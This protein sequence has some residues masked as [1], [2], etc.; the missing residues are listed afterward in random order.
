VG[1]KDAVRRLA[2]Q[3]AAD[4][5]KGMSVE[6]LTPE[7]TWRSVLARHI[8]LSAPIDGNSSLDRRALELAAAR[9]LNDTFGMWGHRCLWGTHHEHNGHV[10]IH[11]L[12]K[13]R[14][15]LG[16]ALRFT[17][18]ALLLDRLREALADAAREFGLDVE[19]TRHA[20][21]PELVE[22][23]LSGR[24]LLPDS[25]REVAKSKERQNAQS[26]AARLVT[27]V[28]NRVPKWFYR[29]GDSY[30][31]RQENAGMDPRQSFWG[32]LRARPSCVP[33]GYEDLAR[34]MEPTFGAATAKAL[35]RFDEMRREEVFDR[36]MNDKSPVPRYSE[37]LL[38]HHPALFAAVS[39]AA[40]PPERVR[41]KRALRALPPPG[42]PIREPAISLHESNAS[43]LRRFAQPSDHGESG[44]R[45]RDV[46]KVVRHLE[47]LAH[48]DERL[49]RH[50]EAMDRAVALRDRANEIATTTLPD[51]G[52]ELQEYMSRQIRYAKLR[53][54][55]K[56]RS[57]K[58]NE[59]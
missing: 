23:L 15:D 43:L 38:L 5:E 35:E 10:H 46:R 48:A 52:L 18:D 53:S 16:E 21:R 6:D 3:A 57:R 22:D 45:L 56:R 41:M 49:N 19:A 30:R 17:K 14:N 2:A 44:R 59:H 1:D 11:V 33:P 50:A 25:A 28:A 13:N 58:Q 8:I 24:T 47:E 4:I 27:E 37:W 36:V 39:T 20:D 42:A 51:S 54:D 29:H 34:V 7:E 40:E 12:V 9:M 32:R 31:Q 55:R 26:R